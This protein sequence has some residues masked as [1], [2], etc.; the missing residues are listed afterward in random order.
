MA[1][2]EKDLEVDVKDP[3]SP[4]DTTGKGVQMLF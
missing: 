3:L 4:C 2:I 1:S